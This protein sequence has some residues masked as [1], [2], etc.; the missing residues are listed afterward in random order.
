M[1][2]QSLSL[3]PLVLCGKRSLGCSATLPF[4]RSAKRHLR[5]ANLA[6]R[7][8]KRCLRSAN[9]GIRS[10]KNGSRSAKNLSCTSMFSTQRWIFRSDNSWKPP[11]RSWKR[12]FRSRN[13]LFRSWK[14]T[15][16]S[17]KS[18]LKSWSDFSYLQCFQQQPAP[19]PDHSF[20]L[21]R[22]SIAFRNSRSGSH[23]A[24]RFSHHENV[25]EI[26]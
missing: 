9:L 12:G 15:L 23:P 6:V 8:A 5:S 16:R 14:S 24:G 17:W 2:C 18:G 3:R 7:S 22:S 21:T 20:S 13:L 19:P 4:L 11:L 26:G 25:A 10:A 1:E